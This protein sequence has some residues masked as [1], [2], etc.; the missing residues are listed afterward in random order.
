V[1]EIM[2]CLQSGFAQAPIVRFRTL[3][4]RMVLVNTSR[5]KLAAFMCASLAELQRS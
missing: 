5:R 2:R 3:S 4:V 1:D